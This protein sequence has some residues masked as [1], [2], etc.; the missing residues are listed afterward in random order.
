MARSARAIELEEA[1]EPV[2]EAMGVELV[3]VELEGRAGRLHLRVYVDRP[4][5]VDH[6]VLT[7]ASKRLSPV[8]DGLEVAPGNYELEV[9]SPGIERVL[10]RP[11]HYK[12]FLGSNVKVRMSEPEE[13]RRNFTGLLRSAGDTEFT[14]EVDGVEVSLPYEAVARAHLVVE[15]KF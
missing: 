1:M 3:G 2:L 7:E 13:G 15:L 5:G 8:L 4:D 14:L 11:E 6:G 12:R 10:F 9:S